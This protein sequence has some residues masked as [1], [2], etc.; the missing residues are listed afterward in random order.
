MKR[1][2]YSVS[3]RRGC[4]A[5]LPKL[6]PLFLGAKPF[7]S[8][9]DNCLAKRATYEQEGVLALLRAGPGL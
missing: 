2:R 4:G 5:S 8:K 9:W 1:T 3:K 6:Y 7:D